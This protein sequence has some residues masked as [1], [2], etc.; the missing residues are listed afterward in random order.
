MI[1]ASGTHSVISPAILYWGTPVVLIT[2][3]NEDGTS[4]NIAPMSSAWWLGHSCMLGLDAT[5]KTTQNLLRTKECVLN[6]ASE[7][8]L[9]AVN[10]LADTTGSNPVSASK[11][12][13][14]YK[15]VKDKW[16][17]ANLTSE[18]SDFVQP[19]RIAEC[20]VQMECELLEVTNM[21][22][23]L[24]D[25]T[26]LILAI[27]VRVLRI[28]ILDELRMEGYANRV[29]PDKWKPLIMNFQEFYGLK[30][31]KVGSSVLGRIS[32]EKYRELTKSDV[33]KLPGDDDDIV[34]SS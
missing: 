13:R 27:E 20:P 28:H 21:R 8:L 34:M 10:A 17:R 9:P 16:T 31:G 22:P 5:S 25:R 14:N 24:P 11:A 4:S 15:F 19:A 23:D 1:M 18:A 2:T 3:Q 29:D 30:S 26:G 32:E 33:T 12:S 7:D 6:L